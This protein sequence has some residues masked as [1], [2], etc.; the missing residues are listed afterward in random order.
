MR[1]ICRHSDI[2]Y[3]LVGGISKPHCFDI[4]SDDICGL[5]AFGKIVML[6]GCTHCVGIGFDQNVKQVGILYLLTSTIL[7]L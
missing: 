1:T 7:F 3:K 2:W 5:A 6:D 4:A